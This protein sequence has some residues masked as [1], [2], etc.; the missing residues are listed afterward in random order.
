MD[1]LGNVYHVKSLGY[2]HWFISISISQLK[3][4]SIPLDKAIYATSVVVNHL[5][6]DTI[7][8]NSKFLNTT[9]PYDI[10][11]TKEDYS[12]SDEHV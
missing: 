10:I 9:L 2:E 1:T 7:K 12:T 11:F 3:Y 8:E 4:H 5:D 6:T